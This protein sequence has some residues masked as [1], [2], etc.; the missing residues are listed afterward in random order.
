MAQLSLAVIIFI[1]MYVKSRKFKI[2]F[3][4]GIFFIL[5]G[6]FSM[7]ISQTLQGLTNIPDNMI[8]VV[9]FLFTAGLAYGMSFIITKIYDKYPV[10]NE[11]LIEYS[12]Y[13]VFLSFL[14]VY[15][16]I[17]LFAIA[18][19]K[20]DYVSIVF[21]II[22]LAFII[23]CLIIYK[24][25]LKGKYEKTQAENDNKHLEQ[26][27]ELL[28]GM[29]KEF[30]SFKHDYNNILTTISGYLQTDDLEGL[31]EYFDKEIYPYSADM[32]KANIRLALLGNIKIKPLKGILAAKLIEAIN[33]EINV[34]IDIEE[35][36][37]NI[38]MNVVDLCRIVGILLDNA[39]EG[40]RLSGE[41][42]LDFGIINKNNT[43]VLIINNS[44]KK[45]VPEIQEIFRVG[46][47]TK[48]EGH[49]IGL[50]N[51]QEIIDS[52]YPNVTLNSEIDRDLGVFKQRLLIRNHKENHNA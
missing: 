19:I 16:F 5:S 45:D 51:V 31:K 4:M 37:D 35:S 8:G 2:S 42:K 11:K 50:S 40:A 24:E 43:V 28:E 15:M 34:F 32:S 13:F 3:F 46:F 12:T 41:K 39:I 36:I 1:L 49:G 48:G 47:T 30:R 9:Q 52:K 10:E 26:Y 25:S 6:L 18:I 17:Y 22:L 23:L 20:L 7:V 27:S 33:Y 44:C 38:N 14:V 21:T 29:M